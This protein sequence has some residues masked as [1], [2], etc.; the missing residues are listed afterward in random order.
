MDEINVGEILRQQGELA[1]SIA[2]TR[3]VSHEIHDRDMLLDYLVRSVFPTDHARAI[4]AYFDGGEDCARR[5]AALVSEHKA[6]ATSILEFASGYGRV[7][8]HAKH[9]LPSAEWVS[10]DIHSEAV[11]F[12][13][14]KVGVPAFLST[15]SPEQ[16]KPEKTFDVVFALSFFS[17]M[18]DVT[19]KAWIEK[20]L[21]SVSEDG[22]LIF[23]THGAD[24]LRMMKRRGMDA[25][26]DSNGYYWYPHSDQLDLAVEE[27]G[28]SAVSLEYVASIIAEIL[29]AELIRFQQGFWWGHQDLYVLKKTNA[30]QKRAVAPPTDEPQPAARPKF[31]FWK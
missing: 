23:T 1:K 29:S 27:Y 10:S 6:S 22:L 12:L 30:A 11:D 21:L 26:F 16:W 14:E 8:R 17:H 4:Q 3:D 15:H 7:A 18:P 25:S 5:F 20:L 28:T 2:K 19:F 31:R 9:V 13:N 24:T